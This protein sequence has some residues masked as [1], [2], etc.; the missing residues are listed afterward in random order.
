MLGSVDNENKLMS[1]N[2]R[3]FDAIEIAAAV[4]AP[5]PPAREWTDVEA[6]ALYQVLVDEGLE[7]DAYVKVLS[8]RLASGMC[9]GQDVEGAT[10]RMA[11][12]T[13][14]FVALERICH[15]GS[16]PGTVAPLHRKDK[17]VLR[18][19]PGFEEWVNAMRAAI[20]FF[21]KNRKKIVEEIAALSALG[22]GLPR[23]IPPKPI[24]LDLVKSVCGLLASNL[25]MRDPV[26]V[27]L[28]LPFL[29]ELTKLELTILELTIF[30]QRQ[31]RLI[32]S[33]W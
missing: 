28:I 23:A 14:A 12:G 25:D 30:C 6:T 31:H 5:L 33:S 2:H 17:E 18:A 24:S 3:P 19:N 13:Q 22:Q 10:F 8:R 21:K 7:V 26:Q 4:P 15:Q 27:C 16:G 20:V 29:L 9:P 1:S 11:Y 32:S